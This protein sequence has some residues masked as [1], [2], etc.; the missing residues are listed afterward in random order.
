M[1]L[2]ARTCRAKWSPLHFPLHS[3][4]FLLLFLLGKWDE[5][6]LYTAA[7]F[8]LWCSFS[9]GPTVHNSIYPIH[10]FIIIRQYN[11]IAIWFEFL[12]LSK[13]YLL[14][15]E[16][17]QKS[18][19]LDYKG[20]RNGT[21]KVCEKELFYIRHPIS[22]IVY[23]PYI[24]GWKRRRRVFCR[25]T[26]R[27]REAYFYE[28]EPPNSNPCRIVCQQKERQK[29]KETCLSLWCLYVRKERVIPYLSFWSLAP[30]ELILA[31]GFFLPL[32]SFFFIQ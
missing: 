2:L 14:F 12:F 32:F 26:N 29:K 16:Y 21:S 7:H 4:L 11:N 3:F 8:T 17:N 31:Q 22:V 6:T 10:F 5:Q 23:I 19:Y 27:A 1:R 25:R 30:S 18:L 20:E 24:Y 28:V 9:A 13:F 15:L